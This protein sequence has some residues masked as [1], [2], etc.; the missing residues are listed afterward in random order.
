MI[1]NFYD[2]VR[3]CCDNCPEKYCSDRNHHI[4]AWYL[5]RDTDKKKY[6]IEK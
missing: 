3:G 5:C 6:V 1:E 2:T 4:L